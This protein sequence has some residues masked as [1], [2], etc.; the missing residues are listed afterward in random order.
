MNNT[1]PSADVKGNPIMLDQKGRISIDCLSDKEFIRIRGKV[2]YSR[3]TRKIEGEALAAENARRAQ[4]GLTAVDKAFTTMTL[5][6]AA[7]EFDDPNNLTVN[8]LYARDRMLYTS[9]KHPEKGYCVTGM[10]KGNSLPAVYQRD[11]ANPNSVKPIFPAEELA[12]GLDVTII[13]RVFKPKRAGMHTGMTLETVICNEPVRTSNG[14][15]SEATMRALGFNIEAADPNELAEYQARQAQTAQPAAVPVGQQPINTA[16][17]NYGAP[18]QPGYG[19]PVQ[20][21]AGYAQPAPQAPNYAPQPAGYAQPAPQ[22]YPQAGAPMPN[23]SSY[24][25]I[26]LDE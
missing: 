8:D 4:L 7:V 24:G 9:N 23:P 14:S 3:I 19:A 15:G 26:N 18:V 20:Q 5:S 16:P 17:N 11:A 6:G 2:D 13:F 12:Q 1:Y 21:P 10:N 25:G 22:G